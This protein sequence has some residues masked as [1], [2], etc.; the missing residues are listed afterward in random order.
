MSQLKQR[1]N[2]KA[3][4]PHSSAVPSDTDGYFKSLSRSLS[5]L[6]PALCPVSFPLSVQTLSRSLSRLFPALCPISFLLSLS[7]DSQDTIHTMDD[8][9]IVQEKHFSTEVTDT[10]H[11]KQRQIGRN[12]PLSFVVYNC[13]N[14]GV[15]FFPRKMEMLPLWDEINLISLKRPVSIKIIKIKCFSVLHSFHCI[16]SISETKNKEDTD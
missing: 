3:C 9:L 12:G 7:N 4:R 14:V 13:F 6:F 11:T 15:N 2:E 1:L 5:S 16:T 10:K 8:A